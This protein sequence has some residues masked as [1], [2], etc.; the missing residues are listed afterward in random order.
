MVCAIGI[1]PMSRRHRAGIVGIVARRRPGQL[2]QIADE[3]IE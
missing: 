3:V 2:Q 1:V